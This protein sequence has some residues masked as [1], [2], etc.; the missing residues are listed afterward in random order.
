MLKIAVCFL[1]IVLVLLGVCLFAI[2][3]AGIGSIYV[4]NDSVSLWL[5]IPMFAVD[6]ALRFC[7][8][9]EFNEIQRHITPIKDIAVAA[10]DTIEDCP[11]ATFLEAYNHGESV[12]IDKTGD[13]LTIA[14]SS[15]TEGKVRVKLP[16]RSLNRILRTALKSNS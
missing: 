4:Q 8:A 9:D 15:T 13:V 2:F 10:V 5:P 16:I 12:R 11:D 14:V 6:M 1:V 7:P 3:N